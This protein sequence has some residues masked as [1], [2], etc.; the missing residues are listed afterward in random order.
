MANQKLAAAIHTTF[1]QSRGTYGAP[2]IHAELRSQG[3]ECSRTRVAR[4]MRK[5]GITQ[6]VPG[7]KAS[8]VQGNYH[9]LQA[10]PA[11]GSEH[12]GPPVLGCWPQ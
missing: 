6:G 3:M 11:R 7:K 8:G 4:L 1:K 2:R 5:A 10:Q 9:P 12:A